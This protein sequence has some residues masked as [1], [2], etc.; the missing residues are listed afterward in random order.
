MSKPRPTEAEFDELKRTRDAA[1]EA[2]FAEMCAEK[3]WNPAD[4]LV[5]RS[6]GSGCYCNCPDG[7]CQHEWNGEPHQEGGM[8][9]STCSRCGEWSINH[10]MRCGP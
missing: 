4:V 10:D 8:W 5:H 6:H 1:Y 2:W 9:T 7:P 3:G